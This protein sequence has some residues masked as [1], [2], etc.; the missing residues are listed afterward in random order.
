MLTFWDKSTFRSI[1]STSNTPR[2][3]HPNQSLAHTE[4]ESQAMWVS[5]W[6]N[7]FHTHP[8]PCHSLFFCLKSTV[9]LTQSMKD[10]VQIPWRRAYCRSH[11]DN[12]NN[13]RCIY[14]HT[15]ACAPPTLLTNKQGW[16]QSGSCEAL[17]TTNVAMNLFN[18]NL[19]R[20]H[21]VWLQGFCNHRCVFMC[22]CT[23]ERDDE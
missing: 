21:L 18:T 11:C 2:W 9:T 6:I 3:P 4:G 1:I 12:N 17:N 22:V 19:L 8:H 5:V 16:T 15:R 10:K 14:N 13:L 23:G 7:W 20:P